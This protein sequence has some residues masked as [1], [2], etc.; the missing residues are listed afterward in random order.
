M[1]INAGS[2]TGSVIQVSYTGAY[3]SPY[4]YPVPFGE[5]DTNSEFKGIVTDVG[6]TWRVVT[7]FQHATIDHIAAQLEVPPYGNDINDHITPEAGYTGADFSDREIKY[8][9][10]AVS[11]VFRVT[12]DIQEAVVVELVPQGTWTIGTITKGQT[13][14]SLTPVYS[15]TDA[16]SFE[17]SIN[18]GAWVAFTGTI[19]LS[20]LTGDTPYSG[21]VRA[22]NAVGSGASELFAFTTEA[23]PVVPGGVTVERE[24]SVGAG[25]A[26][27]PKTQSFVFYQGDRVKITIVHEFDLSDKVLRYRQAEKVGL[28]ARLKLDF[29]DDIIVFTTEAT[30][31]MTASAKVWQVILRQG[32]STVVVAEGT[33]TVK[34]RIKDE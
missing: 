21:A 33:V 8:A 27:L 16:D 14:A 17:Y 25:L 29:A 30:E 32:E 6:A 19:S 20:G 2:R 13:T 22:T 26:G 15:L 23:V 28:P 1:I 7:P 10:G 34:P 9:D 11:D 12:L 4:P 31:L 3:V 18:S 24:Y 5:V